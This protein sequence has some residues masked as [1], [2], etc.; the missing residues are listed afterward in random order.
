MQFKDF[1]YKRPDMA[2]FS[3]QFS[4]LLAQ[5]EQ[6]ASFDEQAALFTRISDMRTD[7]NSMYNICYIRH[8]INTKDEFYEKEQAFYDQELPNFE[9]L[10]QQFYKKLLS[11]PF[12]KELEAHWGKQLF[13]IAAYSQ[14]TFSPKIVEDLQE[15]NR[16]STAY[17]QL[18]AGAK[19]QF[20]GEECNLSSIQKYEHAKDRATRKAAAAAKWRFFEQHQAEI[21]TIFDKLVKLRHQIATKLGYRNFVELAYARML[22][23]DYDANMVATFRAQVRQHIVPI[24]TQ[25][26]ER[27][28]RRMQVDTLMYYDE[29]VR[30]LSGNPTPKGDAKWIIGNAQKMYQALS[31]ETGSF[32]DFMLQ[33]EL[34]DVETRPGKATGGYCTFIGNYKSPYIF[35]NFNGT[36]GD[37]E[38]LTHEAGHAFQMYASRNIGISEYNF[39]TYEACEIHSMSMEFFTWPW[40]SLFFLQDADKFK[41]NHISNSLCFLPYGVAVDEFQHVVYEN[42]HATPQE[43]NEAWR[44]IER[45]Y[46]P[47]RDYSENAFLENGGFWQ[48]QNHIFTTPFYY[49]DYVLAQ[50]CAFQFWKKDGENHQAAWSDYVKLCEA[51]GSLSFLELVKLA[52]LRSPFDPQCIESVIG[53]IEAWLDRVDDSQF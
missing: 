50:I 34:L 5:F 24:A 42:P 47:Q 40:M 51:G 12:R 17:M 1:Q 3:A 36:T 29:E 41:F 7:F 46:L 37:I 4:D 35:S 26:Y 30:F 15:E 13:V 14:K 25:L 11:S 49:I 9:A 53:L 43:R 6:A 28:R 10:N 44:A 22:R 33:T 18:K 31:A 39:P 32:F 2:T 16:L 21:E 20:N 45:K 52:N 38:V 48:K 19:I 27:Q 23:S 8:T